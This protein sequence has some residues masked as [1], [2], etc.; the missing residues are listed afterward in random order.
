MPTTKTSLSRQHISPTRGSLD[1]EQT[2]LHILCMKDHM[3]TLIMR[4][5]APICKHLLFPY[6]S[7]ALLYS[8]TLEGMHILVSLVQKMEERSNFKLNLL[9]LRELVAMFSFRQDNSEARKRNAP[10]ESMV[11]YKSRRMNGK[12]KRLQQDMGTAAGVAVCVYGLFSIAVSR[13]VASISARRSFRSMLLN[14]TPQIWADIVSESEKR[15][16]LDMMSDSIHSETQP[17]HSTA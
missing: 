5:V 14:S 1:A 10:R 9:R 16:C 2:S 15:W 17:Q 3:H 12:R 8:H 11:W 6:H 4:R 7:L 13:S